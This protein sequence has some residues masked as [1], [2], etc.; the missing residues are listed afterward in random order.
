[1]KRPS[2][3]FYPGDWLRD[4]ALRLCTLEARGLWIDMICLMH[5]GNPYG[6]LRVSLKDILPPDLARIVGVSLPTVEGYLKELE[7]AGVFS[8]TEQ[9][10]I[11]SKRMVND[12]IL[13]NKR[14][15]GG[16]L[17]KNNPNVPQKKVILEGYPSDH[18]SPP[19]LGVSPSSSS[20]SSNNI[21]MI[22]FKK[23]SVEEVAEYANSLGFDLDA[24]H[25][26]DYHETRGWKLKGGVSVKDWK[27]CIRTWKKNRNFEV[28]SKQP[29]APPSAEEVLKSSM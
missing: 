6:H 3:Q 11:F 20:S 15:N 29:S 2:F 4:T 14:A 12:E 22:K 28:K 27:A 26:L 24:T 25:F 7:D 1:M 13:R 17:S 18:P 23:P 21:I 16:N 19:S 8:R 10:T 5:E 9:G